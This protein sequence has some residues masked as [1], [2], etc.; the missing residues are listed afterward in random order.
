MC[1]L[2]PDKRGFLYSQHHLGAL[3]RD[4]C[5]MAGDHDKASLSYCVILGDERY[6]E[7]VKEYGAGFV[8]KD[9]SKQNS[10]RKKKA[11]GKLASGEGQTGSTYQG[12]KA[13]I[14]KTRPFC[15]FL[16]N[17]VDVLDMMIWM[18]TL[19]IPTCQRL[20]AKQSRAISNRKTRR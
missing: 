9:V 2:D 12:A 14:L 10:Q 15:S 6:P 19:S 13:W 11:K 16:E 7:W 20:R 18:M 1:E 5:T 4:I 8:C 3:Y 17:V